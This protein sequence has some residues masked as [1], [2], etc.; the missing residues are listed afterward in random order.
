VFLKFGQAKLG[1][2]GE[3]RSISARKKIMLALASKVVESNSK[4][5]SSLRQSK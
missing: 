1:Y 5:T 2:G 4:I 3:T